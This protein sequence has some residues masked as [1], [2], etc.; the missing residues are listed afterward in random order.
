VFIIGASSNLASWFAFSPDKAVS[1]WKYDFTLVTVSLFTVFGFILIAPACVWFA[2]NYLGA[3]ATSSAAAHHRLGIITLLCIYG[4]SI[5]I[6]LPAAVSTPSCARAHRQ[7]LEF[8]C[9]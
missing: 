6:Y 8:C 1:L 2:L 7:L 5:S 4:Y 9:R 3:H